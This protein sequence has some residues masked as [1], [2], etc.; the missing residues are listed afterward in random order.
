MGLFNF[1]NEER[2]A[3]IIKSLFTDGTNNKI[4]FN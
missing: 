3:T 2:V 4:Q 1:E